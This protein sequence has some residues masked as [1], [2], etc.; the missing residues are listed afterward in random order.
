MHNIVS[1]GDDS[2]FMRRGLFRPRRQNIVRY[3]PHLTMETVFLSKHSWVKQQQG[4]P[5]SNKTATDD[6]AGGWVPRRVHGGD[7]H[8]GTRINPRLHVQRRWQSSRQ[9]KHH[10]QMRT[11]IAPTTGDG[12][13]ALPFHR[14]DPKGTP[15]TEPPPPRS[16]S[17]RGVGNLRVSKGS[18]FSSSLGPQMK[19]L[20]FHQ[21]NGTLASYGQSRHGQPTRLWLLCVPR[22]GSRAHKAPL[23]L[24]YTKQTETGFPP[25]PVFRLS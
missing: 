14:W 15:S 19:A 16:L 25:S 12:R 13:G 7:N 11:N 1:A 20:F 18:P 2:T 22:E 17:G 4:H 21:L 9:M 8:D 23:S 6:F 5:S 24:S 3:V 10:K